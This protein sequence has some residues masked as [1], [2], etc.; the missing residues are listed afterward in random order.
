MRLIPT[1]ATAAA[2]SSI[3][4]LAACGDRAESNPPPS[5][6]AAFGLVEPWDT[7]A[8]DSIYGASPVENLRTLPVDL[9]LLGIPDG[10]DGMRIAVVSDLQLG[11]WD[12]NEAVAEAA[13]QRAVALRPDLVALLGDF[14]A[15]GGDPN[16]IASVLAPLRG[17]PTI[18]VLGDRD[19]RSDSIAAL[20][21][22]T[23]ARD[24]IRVLRNN[25]VPWSFGGDTA[26]IGGVDP[27]LSAQPEGDQEWILSQLGGGAR[28]G[29]LLTH[30]PQISARAPKD[31]F[32]G[33]LAGGT[34][35]GRVEVPGSPRLSW[36]AATA[37]PGAAVPGYRRFFR[38]G[39]SVMFVTCGTGYGFVP[40]RFGS[41]PEV[42]LVTLHSVSGGAVPA[43][44][45][46]RA[47]RADSLS[48]DTLLRRYQADSSTA[49][50]SPE[51]EAAP[52]DTAG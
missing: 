19:I 27:D 5:R 26:L 50:T 20:T 32:P 28:F 1:L 14:T 34:F 8:P 11:L 10:W 21:A 42:A 16:R 25:A 33:I 48:L 45:A 39:K 52:S 49:P 47:A 13:V 36:L 4:A 9:D 30:H 35:C 7:L 44:A 23:L 22:A 51:A 37:L 18:A 40:V 15:A 46:T 17:H 2:V 38:F 43:A 31:R 41:V 3:L 29:L 6:G 12:G 24:G